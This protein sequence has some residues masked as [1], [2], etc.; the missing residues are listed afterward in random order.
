LLG[1]DAT[2]SETTV[3]PLTLAP[4]RTALVYSPLPER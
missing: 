2:W 3:A 1:P 4:F